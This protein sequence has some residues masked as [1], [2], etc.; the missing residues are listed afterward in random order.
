MRHPDFVVVAGWA[1]F[2]G[3]LAGLL[4]VYGEMPLALWTFGSAAAFM[5]LVALAV[6]VSSRRSPAG[7]LHY[8]LPVGG[9]AAALP[10]ALAAGLAGLAL[11]YGLWLLALAVPLAGVSVAI[12]LRRVATKGQ[13]T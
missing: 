5:L 4:G 10:A 9:A 6:L 12:G 2:N 1:V 7:S 13:H 8:R 3:F 11:V